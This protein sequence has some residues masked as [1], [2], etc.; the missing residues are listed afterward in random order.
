MRLKL[1]MV[2]WT[3]AMA[4]FVTL[5]VCIV[6]TP[7]L[8]HAAFPC[9]N[10]RISFARFCSSTDS[11]ATWGSTASQCTRPATVSDCTENA[12]ANTASSPTHFLLLNAIPPTTS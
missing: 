4:L 3:T 10:D 11:R 12:S 5:V 2:K 9:L 8:V 7:R 1:R 6:A